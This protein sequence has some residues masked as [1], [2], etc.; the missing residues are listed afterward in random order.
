MALHSVV[1]WSI[2]IRCANEMLSS[3]QLGEEVEEEEEAG[4]QLQKC[5][6]VKVSPE[7]QR[8]KWSCLCLC[9]VSRGY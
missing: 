2:Y 1:Y 8:Q 9:S 7:C 5:V 6:E 3:A 4:R